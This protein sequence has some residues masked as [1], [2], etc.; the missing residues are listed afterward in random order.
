MY[1][2]VKTENI[3]ID[4]VSYDNPR[5]C[6]ILEAVLN[7]WFQNPKDLHFTDPRMGYPFSFQKWK[8]TSY[9]QPFIET[10]LLKNDDWIIG[11]ASVMSIPYQKRKHLFHLF[12]DP[13]FR[14]HGLGKWFMKEIL[15]SIQDNDVSLLSLRVS[16][17]NDRAIALYTS[18]GF[19]ITG[20][21]HS[22]SYNMERQV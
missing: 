18:L 19:S 9:E 7:R 17:K 12:I 11:H 21:T 4:R 6:R 5:H 1:P 20:K 14:G 8:K 16:P 15:G 13:E 22:G 3:H 2:V 10:F